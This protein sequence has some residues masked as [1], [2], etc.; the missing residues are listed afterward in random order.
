MNLH[1]QHFDGVAF[2]HNP[3]L[4][5]T[6]LRQDIFERQFRMLAHGQAELADDDGFAHTFW[7]PLTI[8]LAQCGLLGQC[9]LKAL[10]YLV[11]GNAGLI[12]DAVLDFRP[13]RISVLDRGGQ[14]VLSGLVRQSALTWLPPYR[15]G[16]ELLL[17]EAQIRR[18]LAD[19]IDEDRWDNHSTANNLRRQADHLQA[20]IIPTRWLPHV[21]KLLNI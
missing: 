10:H 12:G 11:S 1:V 5:G 13:E 18:L 21:L 20:R 8:E 3:Y 16:D 15:T 6:A 7:M 9:L 2:V 17:A 4:A 19:A 14:T